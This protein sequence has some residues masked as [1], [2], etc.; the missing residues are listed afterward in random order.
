MTKI[1]HPI[2]IE[3]KA[4]EIVDKDEA[5]KVSPWL[6][7]YMDCFQLKMKPVTQ[8]F[9]DRLAM[10]LV[11]WARDDKKALRMSQFYVPR[12]IHR[13]TFFRWCDQHPLMKAA[14]EAAL[15]LIA[16]RREIGAITKKYDTKIIMHTM[17]HYDSD[18]R[19]MDK[20][21]VDLKVEEERAPHTFN[22]TIA[23]PKVVDAQEL[24]GEV[25]ETI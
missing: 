18:W 23:K 16:D 24:K 25:D 5:F 21:H 4:T 14:K 7:D 3:T 10:E 19:N 1:K 2:T 9:I 13:N 20:H 22:I 6:E 11:T 8:S 12:G 17:H 15:S